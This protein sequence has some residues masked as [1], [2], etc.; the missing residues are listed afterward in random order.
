[1]KKIKVCKFNYAFIIL[2]VLLVALNSIIAQTDTELIDEGKKL[3]RQKQYS[4]AMKKWEKIPQGSTV[5]NKAQDFI[6]ITKKKIPKQKEKKE[7]LIGTG[8]KLKYKESELQNLTRK[9][10][11]EETLVPYTGPYNKGV[12][13]STLDGKVICGYQGWFRCEG[14]GSG[15]GWTH[16]VRN[17]KKRPGPDNIKVDQWPDVSELDPDELY[18]TDYR[19]PDGTVRKIFSSFNYKTVVRHFKW[20]KEA[21]IDGI[22]LYRFLNSA[23]KNHYFRAKN[24]VLDS[25]RAGANIYGRTYAVKYDV[26]SMKKGDSKMILKDWGTLLERMEFDKDKS[27]QRH[28]GKIV[29]CI[30]WLGVSHTKKNG[31]QK[32]AIDPEESIKLLKTLKSDPK[33]GNPCI[34][35]GT[36]TGWRKQENDSNPDPNYLNLV[37]LADV[38][39]PWVVGRF[40]SINGFKKH[41]KRYI[42]DDIKWLKKHNIDFMPVAYPG[43]SRDNMTGDGLGK[44]PRL[45]GKFLAAQYDGYFGQGVRMIFQAIFDEMDEGTAI[46]KCVN[47]PPGKNFITYEGLPSDYYLKYIGQKAKELKENIKNPKY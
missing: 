42:R 43:F 18:D 16:W 25:C 28:N 17:K 1:M 19:D 46:F 13:A 7:I 5:Y 3:Y 39:H 47:N 44:Y 32:T 24:V 2:L 12:D 45:K 30:T 6:K 38:V 23:K 9:Q 41:I 20:M 10:V 14:D 37:K 11:I 4:K 27:Y 33:Y 29:L 8:L 40:K 31:K 22:F 36:P 34:V 35:L 15:M 26:S 21:G